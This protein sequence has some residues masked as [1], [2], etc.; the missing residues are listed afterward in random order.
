[1]EGWMEG[2]RAHAKE[3]SCSTCDGWALAQVWRRDQIK[4]LSR[5]QWTRDKVITFAPSL[6]PSLPVSTTLSL[7]LG[8]LSSRYYHQ[9]TAAQLPVCGEN[10]P[11]SLSNVRHVS[12]M[13]TGSPFYDITFFYLVIDR[14]SC[15]RLIIRIQKM[16]ILKRSWVHK[17]KSYIFFSNI[18][19]SFW[20]LYMFPLGLGKVPWLQWGEIF[21]Y[22]VYNYILTKSVA[23]TLCQHLGSIVMFQ[24]NSASVNKQRPIKLFSSSLWR[25]L[26]RQSS[27]LNPLQ[28]LWD[29]LECQQQALSKA[30]VAEWEQISAAT[31]KKETAQKVYPGERRLWEKHTGWN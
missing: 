21:T 6:P 1:M 28:H 17:L 14:Y 5:Q 18:F 8:S 22:T 30:L 13:Y 4:S 29:E 27:D 11:S 3:G 31:L 2:R 16:H 24:H 9:F 26:I 20:F 7:S 15:P 12:I 25:N 10:G 23:P 19:V